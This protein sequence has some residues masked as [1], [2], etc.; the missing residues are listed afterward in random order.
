MESQIISKIEEISNKLT[1]LHNLLVTNKSGFTLPNCKIECNE[2]N[3][4]ETIS[5]LDKIL[6]KIKKGINKKYFLP[7]PTL[8]DTLH[9][10]IEN[11][12][13]NFFLKN[14]S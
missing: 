8:P 2:E 4:G 5:I 12:F 14:N 11:E 10:E 9:W 6:L 7:L 1:E 13:V 3:Y